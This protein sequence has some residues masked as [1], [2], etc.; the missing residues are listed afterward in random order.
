MQGK[1]KIDESF[2]LYVDCCLKWKFDS[3]EIGGYKFRVCEDSLFK[4]KE[5]IINLAK[6]GNRVLDKRLFKIIRLCVFSFYEG[7]EGIKFR[8]VLLINKLDFMLASM[9][10]EVEEEIDLL[11]RL[12]GLAHEFYSDACD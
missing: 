2:S 4:N 9:D 5:E 6:K 12:I 1:E 3:S 8:D 10:E 11:F 7:T